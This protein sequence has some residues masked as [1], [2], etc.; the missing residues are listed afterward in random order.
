M[1][2]KKLEHE[3]ALLNIRYEQWYMH[4]YDTPLLTY[5]EQLEIYKDNLYIVPSVVKKNS[6][7]IIKFSLETHKIKKR[8]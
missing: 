6:M 3:L 4:G 7:H 8:L 2:I 1:D 5:H